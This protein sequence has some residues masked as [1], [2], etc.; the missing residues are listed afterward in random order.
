M[1]SSHIIMSFLLVLLFVQCTNSKIQNENSDTQSDSISIK[2]KEAW[3]EAVKVRDSIT[4][5]VFLKT[6]QPMSDDAIAPYN[7]QTGLI[8]DR[9]YNQVVYIKAIK[10]AKKHLTVKN[11]LFVCDLKAGIDINISEDLYEYIMNFIAVLL[12]SKIALWNIW[13]LV[14]YKVFS[15]KRISICTFASLKENLQMHKNKYVFAQLV[16]F[17]DRNKFNYIVRK[18]DGDKYEALHLLESTT[19]FNVRATF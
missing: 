11:G 9:A 6:K 5:S 14:N 7:Y 8:E 1:N 10:R 3:R 12:K 4:D 16:S 15:I 17:L 13:N 18:Y 2:N 19:C